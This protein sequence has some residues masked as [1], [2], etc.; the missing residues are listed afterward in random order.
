M[1]VAVRVQM[2][3]VEFDADARYTS[4]VWFGQVRRGVC[5]KRGLVLVGLTPLMPLGLSSTCVYL[6]VF[7]RY[8][9]TASASLSG[10]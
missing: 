5:Y 3:T 7:E 1:L 2:L 10:C 8:P 6:R 4:Q 9:W